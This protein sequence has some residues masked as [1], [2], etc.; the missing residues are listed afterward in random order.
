MDDTVKIPS[1]DDFDDDKTSHTAGNKSIHNSIF[2]RWLVSTYGQSKLRGGEGAVDIAGGLGL[3]SFDLA[4]RYGIPSTVIEPREIV[5]KAITR[6]MGVKVTR[7]RRRKSLSSTKGEAEGNDRPNK[8]QKTDEDGNDNGNKEKKGLESFIASLIPLTDDCV[9]LDGIDDSLENNRVPYSHLRSFFMWPLAEDGAPCPSTVSNGKGSNL[10]AVPMASVDSSALVNALE[11]ASVL[12][13]M[14]SD[15][16]TEAIVDAALALKKPF[17]V[18]PCCVFKK[19][20]P[21]RI[22]DGKVVS[23]YSDLVNYIQAKDPSIKRANL[24][25]LGRNVC[26]YKL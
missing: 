19:E 1:R 8:R 7:N 17:A 14:H 24:P 12:F 10:S 6:R 4:V 23:T 18:V 20:N 2:A 9:V 21:H 16:A 15:Q 13:G 5:L 25:F 22:L 26:L 3:V 11:N